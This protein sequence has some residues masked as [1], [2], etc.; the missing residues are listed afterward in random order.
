MHSL[1]W[2]LVMQDEADERRFRRRALEYE[3]KGSERSDK[4]LLQDK[5]ALYHTS[6]SSFQTKQRPTYET[7]PSLIPLTLYPN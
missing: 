4:I 2:P 7:P 5:L 6:N 3:G 1:K